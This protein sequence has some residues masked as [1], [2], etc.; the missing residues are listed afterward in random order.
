MLYEFQNQRLRQ[1]FIPSVRQ[2]KAAYKEEELPD[3]ILWNFFKKGDENAFAFIYKHYSTLLF[4][5]GCKCASDK[6]MVRDC[7][8]DFFLY[9]RNN[10]LGFGE[11]T[12]IKL[13]LLKAFRRR[14]VDYLK[15]TNNEH[16]LRKASL[17][18]PYGEES[19][20]ELAYINKQMNAEQLEKLQRALDMLNTK[21]RKVI[22]YFYFEGL[23]Y[24]Q[25]AA[26]LHFGHVSS[27][28][29]VMYR[30]L[31]HLRHFYTSA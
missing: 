22:Y 24:E 27:V 26:I 20:A 31:R 5:Y 18:T 11:T 29:R 3:K 1:A 7:L 10:R 25:I 19:S 8:H 13:Y 15:K 23:S 12:S 4:S 21:E 6:E 28:R 2:G 14:I 17:Y 30:S 16:K 9:L